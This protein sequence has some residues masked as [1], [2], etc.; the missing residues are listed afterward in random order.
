MRAVKAVAFKHNSD[1]NALLEAFNH[2]VN[3]CIDYAVSR[4]ITSPMRLEKALYEEFKQKYGFATHYCIS[5]CR[6]ACGVIRSWRRLKK[7]GKAKVERPAFDASMMR[8]QKELMRFKGDRIVI[9][10]KPHQYIEIPLVVGAYQSMFLDAWK[11]GELKVGESILLRDKV[12]VTFVREVEEKSSEGYAAVDVNL[13]NLDL[14][15]VKGGAFEYRKIDLKKLYGVRVHYFKKR[16]KIQSLSKTKPK[17]SKRLMLKY[18]KRER[19]R[20]NDTL[21]KLTTSIVDELKGTSIIFEN[22]KGLSYNATR[23]KHMKCRNRK[24]SSLPYRKIQGFIEYKMAWLGY[25]VHYMSARNTSRTCPR[26]G[27]LSKTNGQVFACTCGYKADR[28]LTACINILKM[29]G[30][31]FALKA[32]NELIERE[33]LSRNVSTKIQYIST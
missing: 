2:M 17:T 16:R 5:A 8:L 15:K 23:N 24:V 28:H 27:R 21:H 25:R 18:S 10:V 30:Q 13:M 14:L 31:G 32:L 33:E 1:V 7:R 3:K 22:L 6:V 26:C 9:T 11:R 20:V 4:G 19:S 29:W 12:I